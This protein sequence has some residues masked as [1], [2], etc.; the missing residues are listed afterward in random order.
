LELGIPV[1]AVICTER[2]SDAELF[3]SMDRENRERADLSNFEQGMMYQKALD[4]GLYGSKRSLAETLGVSHTW[5]N[6]TLSVANLPIPIIECFKSPLE[7]TYRHAKLINDALE[8]DRKQVLKRAEKLRGRALSTAAVMNGLLNIS[9]KSSEKILVNGKNVGKI[10][11]NGESVLV[12]FEAKLSGEKIEK[13]QAFIQ[14]L[15]K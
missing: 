5:V 3:A 13:V 11:R 7:V 1:L 15:L 2:I 9:A 4:E 12:R 6:S 14:D 10:E 8:Q